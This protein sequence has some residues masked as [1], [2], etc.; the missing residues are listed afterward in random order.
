MSAAGTRVPVAD[1]LLRNALELT[2]RLG[3]IEGEF[4]INELNELEICVG[5]KIYIMINCFFAGYVSF[6]HEGKVYENRRFSFTSPP[7]RLV[8]HVE[9]MKAKMLKKMFRADDL[10][11]ILTLN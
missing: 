5:G 6:L 9:K 7:L 10:N 11:E 2:E 3:L 8:K 4:R 1:L